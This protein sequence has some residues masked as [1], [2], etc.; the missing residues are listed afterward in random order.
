MK[1]LEIKIISS[2]DSSRLNQIIDVDLSKIK[3]GYFEKTI[4]D[5]MQ[6]NEVV[7]M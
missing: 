2:P 4:N 3:E 1:N 6:D 5:L 7:E